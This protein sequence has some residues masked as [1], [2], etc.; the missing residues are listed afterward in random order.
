MRIRELRCVLVI[1]PRFTKANHSHR[2]SPDHG[3]GLAMSMGNHCT[4]HAGV[5]CA[6]GMRNSRTLHTATHC[7]FG[8]GNLCTSHVAIYM[9]LRDGGTFAPC[10]RT[11]IAPSGRVNLAPGTRTFICTFGTGKPLHFAFG[12]LYQPSGR[13]TLVL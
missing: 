2:F 12:C 1:F 11:L 3:N 10:I 6:C 5:C 13:G 4:S 8:T 9:Y 7:T